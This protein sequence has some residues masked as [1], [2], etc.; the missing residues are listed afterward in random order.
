MHMH[1]LN[2]RSLYSAEK[3]YSIK[4][5]IRQEMGIEYIHPLREG[6][7]GLRRTRSTDV[8]GGVPGT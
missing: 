1:M 3:M 7:R 4:D 8:R 6:P 5:P 2:D